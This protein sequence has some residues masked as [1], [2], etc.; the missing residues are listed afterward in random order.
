MERRKV[1]RREVSFEV[2]YSAEGVKG[3]APSRQ[4]SEF[5]ILIGP[6]DHPRLLMEKHIQLSFTLPD[7]PPFQMRGYCAY[8]TTT[9]AGIRFDN[10]PQEIKAVLAKFVNEEAAA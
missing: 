4:L 9:A 10:V 7:H 1:L 8:I 2:A 3:R 5:G 6:L